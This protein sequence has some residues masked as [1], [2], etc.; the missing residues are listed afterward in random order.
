MNVEYE[1]KGPLFQRGAP[2]SS[3]RRH[4]LVAENEAGKLLVEA[5]RTRLSRVLRN[6]TGFYASRIAYTVRTD[7]SVEVHDSRVV[8]G[9]WLE[10]TSRRNQ[11]TRFKGYATFRRT[12]QERQAE[13]DARFVRSANKI[14]G[15][16]S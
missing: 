11:S 3:V 2:Q 4:I 7:D 6:P 1:I 13:V 10:G 12:L 15:D 5:I 14:V 8:Y 9:P 16:L